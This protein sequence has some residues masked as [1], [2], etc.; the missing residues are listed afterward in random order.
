LKLAGVKHVTGRLSGELNPFI[1]LMCWKIIAPKEITSERDINK[2][3][4]IWGYFYYSYFSIL[5][6]FLYNY[7][8]SNHY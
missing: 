5:L 6:T 1:I 8:C 2:N 3:K 7:I 4:P